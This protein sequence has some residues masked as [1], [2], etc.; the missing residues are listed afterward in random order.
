MAKASISP[1]VGNWVSEQDFY[2]REAEVEQVCG[3]IRSGQSLSISAPRRVG[4]TS[5]MREVVRLLN[6]EG[7]GQI[8]SVFVDVEGAAT[9]EDV[10]AEVAACC[11]RHR[12]MATTVKRW[13][14]RLLGNA[15][16]DLQFAKIDLSAALRSDWQ[17]RG[18]RLL[19]ELCA[20]GEGLVLVLDELPVFLAGLLRQSSDPNGRSNA[21]L[22]LSWLRSQTQLH[23]KR[24]R[25]VVMG[26]IGLGPLLAEAGLSATLNT[27]RTYR[28]DPWSPAVTLGALHA[29]ST[30]Q[31]VALEDD[32]AQRIVELLGV[33]VPFHV[34]LFHADLVDDAR[35]R[36]S[37]SV[38]VADVER[39]WTN[40]ILHPSHDLPHWEQRLRGALQPG[41]FAAAISLLTEAALREPLTAARAL[42][43]L[44]R[45]PGAVELARRLLRLLEHDGYLAQNSDGWYFPFRLLRAWWHA[46][47]APFH[48]V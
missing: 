14:A 27:L 34:Q 4:K 38:T 29:L 26:S 24:L 2:G 41:D 48:E 11:E 8:R 46:Q 10:I 21:D 18:A 23:G 9:P 37:G 16:V 15:E 35:R 22:F 25:L 5:L 43:I 19:A 6:A 17:T 47:Y 3:M 13:A 28:V 12:T 44:G 1:T 36:R 45:A 7:A 31:R 42:E 39:V 32:A 33:G 20:D 40:L 30:S